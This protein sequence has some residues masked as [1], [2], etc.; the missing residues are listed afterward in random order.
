M[1]IGEAVDQ[2][3]EPFRFL[4]RRQ[5]LALQVLD[6]GDLERI[7]IADQRRY[8]FQAGKLRGTPTALASHERVAVAVARNDNRL[9]Q[10]TRSDRFG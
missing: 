6:H 7:V 10:A 1:R 3:S 5:I 9:Q 8:G 2:L 4:Q